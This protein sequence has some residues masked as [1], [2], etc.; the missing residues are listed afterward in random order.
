MICF[1][2]LRQFFDD[3]R[4]ARPAMPAASA[5]L[6]ET[7]AARHHLQEVLL[8]ALLLLALLLLQLAPLR[9]SLQAVLL[10]EAWNSAS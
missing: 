4:H 3:L 2:D 7:R 5:R 10:Q 6:H 8:Q 9:P 1:D